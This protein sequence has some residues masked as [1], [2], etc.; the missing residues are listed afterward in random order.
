MDKLML[1]SMSLVLLALPVDLMGGSVE[2][3]KAL[4]SNDTIVT[5]SHGGL[6][7]NEKSMTEG[8][9]IIIKTDHSTVAAK[10]ARKPRHA[11]AFWD[12]F[13]NTTTVSL[14]L[15]AAPKDTP[16]HKSLYN[17]YLDK[18]DDS[19]Y[20]DHWRSY[21]QEHGG[22]PL[23]QRLHTQDYAEWLYIMY[24]ID[25]DELFVDQAVEKP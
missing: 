12:D 1:T 20:R 23:S 11:D 22:A 2:N 13:Y 9:T 14:W 19:A 10:L 6:R 24:R 8:N 4:L 3:N 17:A 18:P 5:S 25:L 15:S 16:R 21:R 7:P